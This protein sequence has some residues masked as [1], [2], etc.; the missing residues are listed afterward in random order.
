MG[1][2]LTTGLWEG[3]TGK[4]L[5]ELLYALELAWSPDGEALAGSYPPPSKSPNRRVVT[6]GGDGRTL[7][8]SDVAAGKSLVS[9]PLSWLPGPVLEGQ[10]KKAWSSDGSVLALTN[11]HE[12]HLYDGGGWPMG[13]LLPGEPF[14]HLSIRSDGHYRGT[15]RVD[16]EIRMVVLKRDGS[17]ETLTPVEFAHRYGWHNDPVQVRLTD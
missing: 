4:A 3:A 12:V 2:S 6:C 10:E 13:V 8:V 7:Y 16:C 9:R 15:A 17:S 1:L 14:E 11:G 5:R